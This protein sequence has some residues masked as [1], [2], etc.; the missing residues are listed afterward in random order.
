MLLH[1]VLLGLLW[2]V[3]GVLHSVFAALR[4]KNFF[5]KILGRGFRHYRLAYTVFAFAGLIALIWFQLGVPTFR[6]FKTTDATDAAGA[7]IGI[8]GV[9]LMVLCIK[10][11]FLN[12]SGL[13]SLYQEESH[14]QLEVTG[15]HRHVRHP[16]YLGT[17]LFLWGL[18]LLFPSASLLISN[19][20]ITVYT[21][22]GLELEE[23]KLLLQFGQQYSTYQKKVPKLLPRFW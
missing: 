10:K 20:V 16:L 18:W 19:S 15:V 11:Y 3:Y 17:F 7:V 23:K 21:L 9:L 1:H 13:R 8:S 4:T 12:L 22:I 2:M 14:A 6:L 5:Q